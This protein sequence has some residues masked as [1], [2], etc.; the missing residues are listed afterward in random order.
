MKKNLP[1]IIAFVAVL[2]L[3]GAL[4]FTNKR[5]A[6]KKISDR[7]TLKYKDKMP[8]GTSVARTLLPELFPNS[9]FFLD[10]N[11]P[12][13]WDGITSTSYNQ[14]VIIVTRDF[15]ADYDELRR[16]LYFA[17]QGNFVFIVSKNFSSEAARFFNFSYIGYS[18]DNFLHITDDSLRVKLEQP[19]FDSSKLFVYP[20]RKFASVFSS[21]DTSHCRVLG[22]N[23]NNEPDF[24]E[25]KA[26][27]GKIFVHSAPL[28][29][30]NYFILHKNNI[31]YFQNVVSVIPPHVDR[32]AWNEYYLS[33]PAAN[34]D[35]ESRNPDWY[36]VLW[37]YPAFK[38]GLLTGILMLV[39]YVLLGSRR[40]QRKIPVHQRPQNDSLDF[41]KTLGRL[42]HD[43]RDHQNLARK[44]SVYFLEHVRS[45]FKLP[46]HTLD[47]T[48][49]KALQFK[50]GYPAEDLR[51]IF[52]FINYLEEGGPVIEEQLHTFHKQL[53]SFYQTT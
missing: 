42:Y 11:A 7:V 49:M 38:W 44:M 16:L 45:T 27:N 22:R 32:I 31:E 50:S 12:G 34:E 30:S 4:L 39:L 20:G 9:T 37:R 15:N 48:F 24:V 6:T 35:K 14:A 1:Y 51:Q 36:R 3:F 52:S 8:Y 17:Q 40:K 13:Q 33:K 43:R 25:F 21:L 28:A 2:A 29:F 18:F 19:V 41:V 53:E 46:T 5:N 10:N 47:E 23:E 26:G